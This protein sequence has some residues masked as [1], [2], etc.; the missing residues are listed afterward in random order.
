MSPM[1]IPLGVMALLV[2]LAPLE[3][4]VLA[5]DES[6]L[7]ISADGILDEQLMP[8]A[9][10]ILDG[11]GSAATQQDFGVESRSE[12]LSLPTAANNASSG[13]VKNTDASYASALSTLGFHRTMINLYRCKGFLAKQI[14]DSYPMQPLLSKRMSSPSSVANFSATMLLGSPRSSMDTMLYDQGSTGYKEWLTKT[15]TLDDIYENFLASA[16]ANGGGGNES[17]HAD[18]RPT[19]TTRLGQEEYF[20]EGIITG[21]AV[22]PD[23]VAMNG[24]RNLRSEASANYY[25]GHGLHPA[26]PAKTHRDLLEGETVEYEASRGD[27]GY[28]RRFHQ[29]H[30]VFEFEDKSL[31]K[32]SLGLKDLFDIALTTLAYLSFGMF[33]LQVIMCI[34]L[35]KS[36]MM[37]LPT[38]EIEVEEDEQRRFVRGLPDLTTTPDTVR[39]QNQLAAY[40]LDSIDVVVGSSPDRDV[41]LPASLCR[42]NRF[43]RTITT[44]HGY[45]ISVWSFGVSWLAGCKT[46]SCSSPTFALKCLSATLVG[47]GNGNCSKLYPCPGQPTKS[48]RS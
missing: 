12:G 30:P 16:K 14:L 4:G 6:S 27:V 28:R 20:D 40:V 1:K 26:P 2:A 43:S 22:Q 39:E 47:L 42:A 15:T 17:A 31:D 5:S 38:P 10:L 23:P 45:W 32:G 33:I 3:I 29:H 8:I 7:M 24:E 34:T 44:I 46:A 19:M 18:A 9:Y 21:Y 41:C 13:E 35:S 36:D 37:V 11:A 48:K 25:R